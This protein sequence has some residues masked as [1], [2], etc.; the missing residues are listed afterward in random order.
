M[1]GEDAFKDAELTACR[2]VCK[3]L[4]QDGGSAVV[5]AGGGICD[6]ILAFE[7]FRAAGHI[8]YLEIPEDIALKRI[9]AKVAK[10]PDGT[11][12]NLP[13]YI[14]K[15]NPQTDADVQKLFHPV[16]VKRCEK[17]ILF[18]DAVFALADVPPEQNA[19][20]LAEAVTALGD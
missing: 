3:S 6:N 14:A 16:Y 12:L 20:K 2:A 19:Q 13:A 17:Y 10:A 1:R 8:V 4:E 11:L 5:A 18:A 7:T 15:D 9:L